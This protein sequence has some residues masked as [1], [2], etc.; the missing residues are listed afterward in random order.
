[1]FNVSAQVD[2]RYVLIVASGPG[3]V[4]QLC[5]A[6][7]FLSELLLR[8]GRRRALIDIMGV[9]F[10]LDGADDQAV[11]QHLVDRLPVLDR[12]AIVVPARTSHGL[13]AT[14]A[15]GKGIEVG[16]FDNLP[17]ADGWLSA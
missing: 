10:E 2:G 13:V 15:R 7:S 3:A 12:L 1:M 14:A 11:L 17:E 5:A 4:A 16:E 9:D 6:I 8:T